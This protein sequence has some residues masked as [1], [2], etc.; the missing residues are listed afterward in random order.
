MSIIAKEGEKKE[1]HQVPAGTVQGV[2][3]DVWD[4]GLQKTTFQGQ[5]KVKHKIIIAFETTEL[6]PDG[7]YQGK[8]MTISKRYTL[9]L[10]EKANL[11]KDL[12]SWRG[13]AFTAEELKGFDIEKLI[14]ANAMLSVVHNQVDGK[15][16]ANVSSISKLMKGMMPLQ[17]E[18]KRGLPDWVKK[19]KEAAV[20]NPESH[21]DESTPSYDENGQEIPF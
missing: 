5:Q 15:T 3:Y 4:I 18:N 7:E 2:C 10:S 11:R 6:I 1:F 16:Y 14:G 19:I 9:S 8:R 17:P 20:E 12:E 21:D 13:K